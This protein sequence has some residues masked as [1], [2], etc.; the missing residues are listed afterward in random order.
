MTMRIFTIFII[1]LCIV[2]QTFSQSIG[3]VKPGGYIYYQPQISSKSLAYCP[4]GEQVK[5]TGRFSKEFINVKWKGYV[6]YMY[7]SEMV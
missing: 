7:H 5:I 4:G 1:F 2:I 6:G 3:Y